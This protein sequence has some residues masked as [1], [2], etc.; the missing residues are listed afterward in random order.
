[1]SDSLTLAKNQVEQGGIAPAKAIGVRV[2]LVS[3][4]IQTIDTLCHVMEQMT[5]HVE[6][7]SDIVSATR[8][9][10]HGKFEAVVVDFKDPAKTLELIK[11]PR[12]M[13][14]HKGAVVFAILNSSTEMPDAFRAGANFALVRPLLP[15]ILLRTLRAAYPMM[16]RERRRYYRCPVQIPIHLSSTSRPEFVATSVNVSEGGMAL[17]SSVPLQVGERV[18][19]KLALPG[20]ESTATISSE[21]CWT[22]NAGRVGL[23]FV[24]VPAALAELLQSWIADRLEECQPG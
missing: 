22:D 2:L 15:A 8:K 20:A 21:V 24:Q 13:T 10:C 11:K 5:M 6:V 14:S 4:D 1:M 12:A 16:V 23:E 9:L 7:C 3:G 18:S 19:L 17:A